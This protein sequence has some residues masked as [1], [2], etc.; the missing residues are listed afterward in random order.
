MSKPILIVKFPAS[1]PPQFAEEIAIHLNNK[2]D[3]VN[4]YH[5]FTIPNGEDNFDFR[6]FNGE[7]TE[8]EYQKLEELI[9]E[10]KK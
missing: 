8:V 2:E 9:E 10:L 6:V 1:Y 5:V 3:L 4:D 7:H